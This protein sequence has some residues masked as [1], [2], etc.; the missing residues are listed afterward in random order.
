MMLEVKNLTVR[1]G[2]LTIVNDISFSLK[3]KQWLMIV[4]PNGAGK[5]T[6]INAVSQGVSYT[7]AI[8]FDGFD[9]AKRKPSE[10][11]KNMGVLTQ[12]H[13]VGYSFSVEEVVRLGRY[14]YSPGVFSSTD[15]EDDRKIED[16][17][18]LTGMKPFRTQSVLTLSG[19][20]LQRTF[21]AQ[22]FAQ[23]PKLL[24]LDEPTNH[25]DLVYQKQVFGLIQDWTTATG[26]AVISVVHDLSLARAY[27]TQ[28][29]LLNKGRLV[30]SGP[31]GE[32]LTRENLRSV[33]SMD[34]YQWMQDMHAQW[35]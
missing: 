27:G 24:I 20:E 17:L 32:V 26:R 9:V 14:S 12:N 6:V 1:F 10:L 4:G 33:Y 13:H 15:D 5:S 21:L 2:S 34:V 29:L 11:A 23:D 31:I 22:L 18:E 28:A 3:E 16:A 30:S 35:N 25:L 7:G 19:G 8:Y